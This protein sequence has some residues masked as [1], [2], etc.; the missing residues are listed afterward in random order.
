MARAIDPKCVACARLDMDRVRQLHGASGDGCFDKQ[1]CY[2]RRSHYRKRLDLNAKRR[3]R[4][5]AALGSAE[6]VGPELIEVGPPSEPVALVYL[7][8]EAPKDSHL[9]ALSVAVWQGEEKVAQTEP[10]HCL[11]LTNRQVN[12]YLGTVQNRSFLGNTLRTG[13]I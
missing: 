1:R 9:H 3:A 13:Q 12:R 10:I 11:G 7:Y 4:Y 5:A 8:R 2:R 6:E